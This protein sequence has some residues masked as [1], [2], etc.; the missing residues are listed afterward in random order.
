MTNFLQ[1]RTA[2]ANILPRKQG[3]LLLTANRIYPLKIASPKLHTAHLQPNA[4]ALLR[5]ERALEQKDKG[6][7]EGAQNLMGRYWQ[8]LGK[9]PNLQG[10]HPSIAAEVLLTLGILTG[11][12]G[13]KTQVEDA[14]ETAKNLISESI[15]YFESVGD[16]TKV[17]AARVEL[18]YCYWWKGEVNEAR[19]MLREALEKLTTQGTVRARALLK[20]TTV[21]HSAA[22]FS[23]ALRI[24]TD[25]A[26]LFLKV[27]DHSTKGQY[28]NQLAMT[29]EEIAVAEK[30]NDYLQRAITEYEAADQQF[31][32]ARNPV[33]RASV[34]NNL[35]VV[36][37]K[38]SRFKEAHKYLDEAKRLTIRFRDKART[39]QIDGTRAQ[40]LIAEGKLSE[41]EAVARRTVSAFERGGHLCL[42]ADALITQGIAVARAERSERAHLIF[43][44]AIEAALKVNALNKAGLAA[45]TLIEEVP[46]LSP[47]TLQAAFQRAREWLKD[48][49]SQ[50]VLQRLNKAA[51]K[52]VSSIQA[53]LSEEDATEILLAKRSGFHEQILDYE[54]GLIKQALIQANGRVTQAASL[55][56][57]SYQ[58]L[59]Y[60]IESRHKDLLK[61]RSP[62]RRRRS[63]KEPTGK[64]N[65]ESG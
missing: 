46:D 35:G 53:E 43:Q 10:L 27:N 33:F 38:L 17:A 24:L 1:D 31:K 57:L 44:K 64:L 45:L 48:S 34:K 40:V 20:L 21:E 16:Q 56:G 58:A 41:A 15:H 36:L 5:C 54:R 50:D 42:V 19:I 51:G 7:H 11:W 18:A 25:N 14:P 60:I 28:H 61:D 30:R 32:L 9:R 59:S 29:L 23:D 8:G 37:F 63:R 2:K 39:A 13:S 65:E 49:Q 3:F 22:R 26:L 12:I 62:V 4:E 47:T 6:D 52:F 55:L